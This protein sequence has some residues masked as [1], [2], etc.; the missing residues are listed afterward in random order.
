[1]T[2]GGRILMQAILTCAGPSYSLQNL[3][4]EGKQGM[5][6]KKVLRQRRNKRKRK[7]ERERVGERRRWKKHAYNQ[8]S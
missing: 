1:V 6:S 5:L 4:L 7:R 3:K 2:G 8:S